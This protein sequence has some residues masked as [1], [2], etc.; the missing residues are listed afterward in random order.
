MRSLNP[1]KKQFP[2]HLSPLRWVLSSLLFGAALATVIAAIASSGAGNDSR[3][4]AQQAA[5]S[6][7][8]APW[9]I[10]HTADGKD[11]EFLVIL[12]DQADLSAADALAT[13]VEKGRY[14]ARR[15]VEESRDHAG[16]G[17]ELAA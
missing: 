5:A 1:M 12:H 13:K 9:V 17:A 2:F 3:A 6:V 4:R 10:D 14:R 16:T 15:L 11:T 8:I 7:K